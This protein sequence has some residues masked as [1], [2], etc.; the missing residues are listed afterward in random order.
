MGP[1]ERGE[2]RV[3]PSEQAS[4]D[5][6]VTISAVVTAH[7][8]RQYLPAAIASADA[9]GA[10]EIVVVRNF[11]GPLPSARA[12]VSDLR[13]PSPE[14][15][16]KEAAGLER[17]HGDVV[18]FL[19]DDDL[20]APEKLHWIRDLWKAHPVLDYLCHGQIPIDAE[21]RPVRARHPEY[22][23]V[24]AGAPTR[25]WQ[26]R[27]TPYRLARER[28]WPGNNSS[29]VVRRSW[30]S[31]WATRLRHVG[32][33]CDTFWLVACY[34][35]G[36]DG[37]LT[38][39]P[40]TFLRLHSE[41]MSQTRGSDRDQFRERHRVM[42][43]RFVH[44]L[45]QMVEMIERGKASAAAPGLLEALRRDE[46]G[47]HLF[48]RL[49]DGSLRRAEALRDL[50]GKALPRTARWTALLSAVSPSLARSALARASLRRWA[51]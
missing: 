44:S 43:K 23:R 49:E 29:T 33:G 6:P 3:G 7:D 24:H 42:A 25:R 34:S 47:W 28:L 10:D 16:V 48:Y 15:G 17:A 50:V 32:W 30:A 11:D 8:R 31:E 19:D 27:Q 1:S 21:G 35:S 36:A 4:R 37:L 20:W 9:A 2:T 26:T 51:L 22:Q 12:S 13:E 40:Q 41:N 45:E 5:G 38:A 18:A 46:N 39:E 14:T